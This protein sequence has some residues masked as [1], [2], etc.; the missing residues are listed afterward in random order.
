MIMTSIKTIC[1][2][3]GGGQCHAIAPWLTNKGYTVNILTSRPQEWNRDSFKYNTPDG[4]SHI[5]SL[6]KIS[7]QPED[8]IPDADVVI[9]TVPAFS[10]EN[11]LKSIKPF[12]KKNAFVGGV[13]A[14]NGFF[15]SADD[16]LGDQFPLWG[17]QRVPFIGKV[18]EYGKEGNILAYKTEFV[19]AVENCRQEQKEAFRK[20][21]EA[22]FGQP[23]K[24]MSH[25]LEVTLSNSNPL[26]HPARIY[27][28][29]MGWNVEVLED[30]PLFYEEWTDEASQVYIDIDYDLHNLIKK[31]PIDNEC[32]PYVLDYYNQ[33]DAHS[34]TL[35]LQSIESFKNIRM[36]VKK[37]D[38]GYVP[39]FTSRYFAEDFLYG[40]RFV[41]DLSK[42]YNV[43]TPMVDKVYQWGLNLISKNGGN[44]GK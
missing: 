32:L 7:N 18:K 33:M 43:S 12:L 21:V 5:V 19:I 23:T 22:A 11:E 15:F 42:K 29:L 17:F 10:N 9:L 31:L 39:D 28:W 25:Y 1:I 44:T 3:G 20:W 14:S 26:L 24:L 4:I 16:V 2:C 35:K 40:L 8:V 38:G 27:T 36:P 6:G 41:Y 34:L 30:N 13:F 37:V